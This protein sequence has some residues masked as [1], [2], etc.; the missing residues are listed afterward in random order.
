M[1]KCS[2]ILKAAAVLIIAI[3]TSCTKVEYNGDKDTPT[4]TF[5][6]YTLDWA[7]QDEVPS[8]LTVV[9]GRIINTVHFSFMLDSI[10]TITSVLENATMVACDTLTG[11]TIPNG[12]Y[13]TMI[14][15]KNT[16][17]YNIDGY[18]SFITDKSFSMRNMYV[19]AKDCSN[20]MFTQIQEKAS[21]FNPTQKYIKEVKP[22]WIDVVKNNI[23]PEI[24]TTIQ[25]NPKPFTQQL[26][27]RVS[28]KADD[29]VDIKKVV[30]MISGVPQRAQIMTGHIS[31]T[32]TCRAP[33]VMAPIEST[34]I[35]EG[36][37]CVL[38]A[39]PSID[40][41]YTTG[42]GIF[43]VLIEAVVGEKS[44]IFHA[45]L[46]MMDSMTEA[47]LVERVSETERL[48][49]I[50]AT[51]ALF[52]IEAKLMIKKDQIDLDNNVP[53]IEGWFTKDEF[54]FEI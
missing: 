47:N 20:D 7:G 10:G 46:N 2:N 13:Y 6:R 29:G 11:L 33:F 52:D 28:I 39:I 19:S 26:T 12:E 51:E 3:S 1:S 42:P 32:L 25:L 43:E 4:E 21:D 38:G 15:N 34:D 35:Y 14:F 44:R 23:H 45:G 31:D 8:E 5:V 40:P 27:F 9:M 24:D 16:E 36:S 17:A 22:V 37:V 30:G 48:Y 50:V 54:E 53:G 49:K 18:D 41:T